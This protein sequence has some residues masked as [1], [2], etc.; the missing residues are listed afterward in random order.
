MA[1]ETKI[2]IRIGGEENGPLSVAEIKR[3]VDENRFNP[4]DFIRLGAHEVWVQAKN[5]EH[6][7]ALF[8][9]RK[10]KREAGA[11]DDWLQQVKSGK[12][13]AVLSRNGVNAEKERI[14][15]ELDALEDERNR[16]ENEEQAMRAADRLRETEI[17]RLDKERARINA[18]KEQLEAASDELSAMTVSMRRRRFLPYIVSAAT[19]IIVLAVGIPGYYYGLYLPG[20]KK[21]ALTKEY[22]DKR[23]LYDDLITQLEGKKDHIAYLNTELTEARAEGNDEKVKSVEAEIIKTQEEMDVLRIRVSKETGKELPVDLTS[24]FLLTGELERTSGSRSVA[25]TDVEIQTIFPMLKKELGGIAGKLR[26]REYK[27]VANFTIT[28]KG[29]VEGVKIVA[30]DF[31]DEAPEMDEAIV[32]ELEGLQLDPSKDAFSGSYIF[33]FEGK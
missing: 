8:E 22:E 32:E 16:L 5:V 21:E 20:K 26:L 14:G 18:E 31:T 1:E 17:E 23:K 6:L 3:L 4:D 13:A 9:E 2:Y 27:V 24:K 15:Q 10:K 25:D 30:S 12:P 29:K 33:T 19:I 11:F 28:K 7:N